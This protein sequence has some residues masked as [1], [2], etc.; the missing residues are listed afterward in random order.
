MGYVN[1]YEEIF[2]QE[3]LK[4]IFVQQV[5]YDRVICFLYFVFR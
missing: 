2:I 1:K 3:G 5:S 4:Q